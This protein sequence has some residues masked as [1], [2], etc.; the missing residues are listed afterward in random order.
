[1]DK[2]TEHGQKRATEGRPTGRAWNDAEQAGPN[3]IL[4]DTQSQYYIV[5]GSRGRV[6][7][8]MEE[9]AR[10]KL[11]TSFRNPRSNTLMRLRTNRWRTLDEVEWKRFQQ[12]LGQTLYGF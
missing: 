9:Q 2:K 10:L 4:R 3:E 1:M 6:H 11:H 5:L 8:F 7:V 12:R